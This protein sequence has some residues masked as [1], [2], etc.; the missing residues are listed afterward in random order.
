VK[1]EGDLETERTI[2]KKNPRRLK[3]RSDR[4]Y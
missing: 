4:Y 3:I 2:Q 1:I